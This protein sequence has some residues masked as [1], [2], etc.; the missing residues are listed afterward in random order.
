MKTTHA[1]LLAA[2]FATAVAAQ[3]AIKPPADRSPSPRSSSNGPKHAPWKSWPSQLAD[4]PKEW[5][6]VTHDH[7][8]HKGEKGLVPPPYKPVKAPVRFSWLFNRP[9]WTFNPA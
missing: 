7:Q 4:L 1:F 5:S 8:G 6:T 3:P 2:I 9:D